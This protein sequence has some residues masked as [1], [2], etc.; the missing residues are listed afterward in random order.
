MPA[1]FID[2]T[3]VMP[4]RDPGTHHALTHAGQESR[5]WPGQARP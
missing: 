5:G 1:C 4:G 2:S 3:A